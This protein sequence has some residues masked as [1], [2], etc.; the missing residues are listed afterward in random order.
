MAINPI[1]ESAK[2]GENPYGELTYLVV[3]EDYVKIVRGLHEA[4]V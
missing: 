2:F 3:R 1:V 4:V